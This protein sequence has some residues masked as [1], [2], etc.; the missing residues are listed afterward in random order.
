MPRSK[1]SADE[2][3]RSVPIKYNQFEATTFQL[4]PRLHAI[5]D[6][7]RKALEVIPELH[8]PLWCGPAIA[9]G[10][11]QGILA[12]L[13]QPADEIRAIALRRR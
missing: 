11:A 4:P 12:P 5:L 10:R 6:V 7:L 3:S 8:D 9:G 2:G 1:A 13:Y